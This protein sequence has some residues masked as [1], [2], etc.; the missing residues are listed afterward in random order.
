VSEYDDI[1]ALL[2]EGVLAGG[3]QAGTTEPTSQSS[4]PTASP[5]ASTVDIPST[6][7]VLEDPELGVSGVATGETKTS[8]SRTAQPGSSS[9]SESSAGMVSEENSERSGRGCVP[10]SETPAPD[11]STAVVSEGGWRTD[12]TD[13]ATASVRLCGTAVPVSAPPSETTAWKKKA[14]KKKLST[15]FIDA[16]E[17]AND[18]AEPEKETL[19]SAVGPYSDRMKVDQEWMKRRVGKKGK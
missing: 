19:V 17:S 10:S 3:G 9:T 14:R 7:E 18:L 13:E 15:K 8:L 16:L 4:K 11:T 2:D 6:V 12:G 5:P 1:V